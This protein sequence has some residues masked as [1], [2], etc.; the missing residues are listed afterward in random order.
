MMEMAPQ[1]PYPPQGM[2]QPYPPQGMMGMMPQQP[3]PPQGM[4]Q[5]Y[6]PQGMMPQGMMP[7][8][9][10]PQG[11]M[12]QGM[13]PQGM[14]PQ[15]PYPPAFPPNQAIPLSDASWGE[16]IEEAQTQKSGGIGIFLWL[17]ILLVVGGGAYAVYELTR[18]PP[19]PVNPFPLERPKEMTAE[20][21]EKLRRQV[22]GLDDEK[23]SKH[24]RAI[25]FA[26]K[27]KP[28]QATTLAGSGDCR[29]LYITDGKDL[30][31][32]EGIV[33]EKDKDYL[34]RPFPEDPFGL[35][36]ANFTSVIQNWSF[37]EGQSGSYL[38]IRH[39]LEGRLWLAIYP[40]IGNPLKE[41]GG[42]KKKAKKGDDDVMCGTSGV[43]E[44]ILREGVILLGSG[45]CKGAASTLGVK[46]H[47]C[48]DTIDI[49]E[50]DPLFF[51]QSG[52]AN[53]PQ[54]T[55]FYN[56]IRINIDAKQIGQ[57]V[58]AGVLASRLA[59]ST[60]PTLDRKGKRWV[61]MEQSTGKLWS[62]D[63]KLQPKDL[64]LQISTQPEKI[65]RIQKDAKHIRA[66]YADRLIR[67][68][69]KG[70]KLEEDKLFDF[71]KNIQARFAVWGTLGHVLLVITQKHTVYQFSENP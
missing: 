11:M 66:I 8:G 5:P 69:A 32:G 40:L 7:Q 41:T 3:Y 61:A 28:W 33:P 58:S 54:G 12:P 57:E 52:R 29:T 68:Q 70:K 36:M 2:M 30:Y 65:L 22:L 44:P 64:D 6:P 19:R 56:K 26:V 51:W 21:K 55:L 15:Q 18:T 13:M 42:K 9:M 60:P 16:D 24:L 47:L 63:A 67:F 10:M 62:F 71:G 43:T 38:L 31:S 20:E 23:P 4:M 27:S 1:Q 49:P 25:E 39:R 46:A 34:Q 17:I 50:K 14:M 53:P 35:R 45:N 59:N 37:A 48:K